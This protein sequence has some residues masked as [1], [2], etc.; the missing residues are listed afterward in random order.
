MIKDVYPLSRARC[1]IVRVSCGFIGVSSSG[2]SSAGVSSKTFGS[3]ESSAGVVDS[4]VSGAS[5]SSA[6]AGFMTIWQ[7][8]RERAEIRSGRSNALRKLAQSWAIASSSGCSNFS[9]ASTVSASCK[10]P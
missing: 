8:S 4:S 1:N 3:K 5:K 10:K 2:T 9:L 6:V 7:Q